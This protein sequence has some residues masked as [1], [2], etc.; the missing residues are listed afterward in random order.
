GSNTGH[1]YPVA[2][3]YTVTLI[4]TDTLGCT[5]TLVKPQYIQI[6]PPLANFTQ[7][8]T[9]GCPPLTV[10][11]TDNSTGTNGIVQWDWNFGDGN[12]GTGT[13]VSHTYLTPGVYTVTLI[14]TDAQGCR[15]T[16]VKPNLVN[17]FAPPIADFGIIDT[18]L[19]DPFTV[20]F[21]DS[22]TSAGSTIVAWA[23]DFGDG[24][25]SNLQNPSH[26]YAIPGNYIISLTV[27]DANGCTGLSTLPITVPAPPVANFIVSDTLGCPGLFVT[28]TGDTTGGIVLFEWDF[29]DGSPVQTGNPV[30]HAYTNPGDYTVTLIVE[31][32]LGCRDTIVRPQLVRIHPPVADFLQSAVDG[33][34]P[35]SVTFTSLSTGQHPAFTL[36]WDFGDGNSGTGTPV[37][38]TYLTPGVYTVT[39]IV[40]DSLGCRD[41][42][43][44][45]NLITVF[46]P[47]LANFGITDTLNCQ[48]FTIQLT[49]STTSAFPITAWDWTFGDGGTSTVQ[50][51]SHAYPNLGTYTITLITTDANGCQDTASLPFT[52][53]L[54][55]T[56]NFVAD[57]SAG[58]TPFA[59][60]FTADSVDIAGYFWTF[61]DGSTSN[62]GPTVVH[63]YL[64]TGH[65]TVTLIITDVFGCTDTLTKPDYIFVDSLSAQFLA[66]VGAGCPPLPVTFTDQ[67]FSDT[68]IVSWLWDFGDGNTSTQQNPVHIYTTPGSYTI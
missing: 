5:D 68:T 62:I 58:C 54:R 51:P 10:S 22:S 16:L 21:Q 61:G 2:G 67:S 57:D 41:T 31:N 26:A 18:T 49:D 11:F 17:V 12:T 24:G 63:S 20:Q 55:P 4:V 65:Y 35:L 1:V 32:S 15:D 40:T 53:P 25:T 30:S 23:W 14:V 19:C 33:C 45:P 48:P 66:D 9:S 60:T 6:N 52:V 29:G 44:K 64:F 27:T 34:P 8:P 37:N 46:Q 28:F 43:V 38:H 7:G 39:L 47:P 42:L 59:V 50:N 56:A 13:P 36:D 3:N